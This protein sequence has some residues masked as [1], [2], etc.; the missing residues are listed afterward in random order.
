ML[1]ETFSEIFKHRELTLLNL[2]LN[3]SFFDFF[4]PSLDAWRTVFLI[5]ACIYVIDSVIF[6]VF[7]SSKPRKWN[8]QKEE[9]DS[10]FHFVV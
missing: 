10:G 9:N 6:A 2:P 4:Q 7:G 1:N 8:E 3:F 5:A